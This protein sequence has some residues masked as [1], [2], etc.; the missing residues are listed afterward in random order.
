MGG[1]AAV[2]ARTSRMPWLLGWLLS[3]LIA[4]GSEDASEGEPGG[5]AQEDAGLLERP[6]LERDAAPDED[7]GDEGELDD[8]AAAPD[9]CADLPEGG[10]CLDEHTYER[11][12]VTTGAGQ[13]QR[14]RFACDVSERCTE[15][16]GGASCEALPE[17]ACRE[18]TSTCLD[19]STLRSCV[20]G[21]LVSEGC[22]AGCVATPL[23]ATCAAELPSRELIGTLRYEAVAPTAELEDWAD[24]ATARP[25]GGFLLLSLRGDALVDA[26]ETS[27]E[28]LVAGSFSI[29]V[30]T[31]AQEDDRLV[32]VAAAGNAPGELAYA[33][34]DP[35]F[36]PSLEPRDPLARQPEP[37]LWSWSFGLDDSTESAE[38]L[39]T[40][41][42]GSG[43]AH[44][45]A[46]LRGVAAF[47]HD[48]YAPDRSASVLV[49][50]GMGVAWSCG[51]CMASS[52]IGMFD[53]SFARQVWLDGS[54]DEGY[55]SD[56]VTSH[57]L[58]HYVMSAYGLEPSEG[59]AH[60]VGAPTHPGQA[61]SEGWAT[62]FSCMMRDSSRYFDKQAGAFFWWDIDLRS[63]HGAE[64][65]WQRAEAARGLEQLIDENE[66]AALLWHTYRE[67][68]AEAPLLD[69]LA[70]PR[71]TEAPFAR[72][73]TRRTWSDPEHPENYSD[74]G[75]SQP[76]LAD[77]FDALRCADAL[78]AA[79]LDAITE[80]DA[81]FPYPAGSPLCE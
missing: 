73:Y 56:P 72:G 3:A 11:C 40:R 38:L 51:A 12:V 18:G 74:T 43:A 35:G 19:E 46:N 16:G 4:C 26:T 14:Q 54:S 2:E 79:E 69:A 68:G 58:G 42:A 71:M 57:E 65:V 21:Q 39:V 31:P 44:V 29:R 33:V 52:P 17:P 7:D 76:Y 50:L 62:F 22:A 53:A 47:A 10:R 41:D 81:H 25:A 36:A 24:T 27:R 59:G 78:S 28:E 60:F 75:V 13:P 30:P 45:F 15:S 32:V 63:Y 5:D 20:G 48:F 66:V 80:P 1:R 8:A 77:Y 37:R 67:L 61:W 9:P 64:L 34:A 70:S 6:E 55:W 49:W 23:G